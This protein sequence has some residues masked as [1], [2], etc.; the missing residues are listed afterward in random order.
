MSPELEAALARVRDHKMTP[1][2]RFEQRVSFIYGQQDYDSPN[3]R[4]KDQIRQALIDVE[5]SPR[6]AGCICPPGAEKTCR[7]P[8]CPRRPIKEG[9]P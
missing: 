9:R 5:G 2:E 1:Q 3:P 4:T 8:M 7:G 6:A